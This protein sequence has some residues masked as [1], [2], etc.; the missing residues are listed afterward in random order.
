MKHSF[1]VQWLARVLAGVGVAAVA[2]EVGVIFWRTSWVVAAVCA[3][4]AAAGLGF[5][6][7]TEWR[8]RRRRLVARARAELSL[9]DSWTVKLDRPLPGGWVA[10]IAAI[11]ED[12]MR[13]VVDI[14]SF[15]SATWSSAPRKAGE[16]PALLDDRD[17]P[18]RPDPLPVLIAGALKAGAAPVLWLPRAKDSGTFRHPDSHVVVVTGSA[19]DLKLALQSARRVP[20]NATAR[21]DSDAA[22]FA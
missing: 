11:R 14:Q 1:L 21:K 13:F 6:A 5:A 12:G 19:R 10:P 15:V 8:D 20:A 2:V 18:L 4:I 9:P 22:Q 3:A 17:K 16:S 7:V